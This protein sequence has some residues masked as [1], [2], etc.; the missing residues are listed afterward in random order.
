MIGARNFLEKNYPISKVERNS[1]KKL[2]GPKNEKSSG[3][4]VGYSF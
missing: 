4:H 3:A 2:S 1:E